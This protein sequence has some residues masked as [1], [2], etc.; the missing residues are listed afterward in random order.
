M[1]ANPYVR[2]ALAAIAAQLV[3][4]SIFNAVVIPEMTPADGVRNSAAYGV[5]YGTV[6]AFTFTVLGMAAGA[7]A[8]K[9]G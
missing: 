3:S 9:V 7:P 1:L 4:G 5:I 2:I 6:A 8:T